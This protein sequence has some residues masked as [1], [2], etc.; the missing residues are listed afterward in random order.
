MSSPSSPTDRAALSAWPGGAAT[1]RV[2]VLGAGAIGGWM[3]GGFARA[4]WQVD[5][6]ARGATLAAL[7]RDGLTL[8][9]GDTT[10]RL[11]VQAVDDP[12]AIAGA[13]VLLLGLKGHDLPPALPS[14]RGLLGPATLVLSAQNG[15][16]WWF[17]RGFGGPAADRTLSG[18]DPGGQLAAALPAERVLAA[19]VHATSRVEAPGRIRLVGQDTVL[20]GDPTGMLAAPLAAVV[21]GLNAGG[22]TARATADI[23]GEIWLK[24]WGNATM[25]PLSALAGAD[26]AALLDDPGIAALVGA[27]MAEMAAIGDR[28]GLPI[29]QSAA[30]RIA[31]TRRL[32]AFRTSMLADREAGRAMER[33]PII[34]CLVELGAVL[35]VPVPNLAAVAGLLRLLE[36]SAG[37]RG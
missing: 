29:R 20:L 24:L 27:M 26:T 15:L 33:G 25:N 18:V 31:T 28:I 14:I 21:A 13:D 7:R 6:L 19:V 5:I 11:P 35:G 3:A 36:A 10:Q 2:A 9:E 37:P 34:G 8:L 12:A 23:R 4:G 17:L 30:T 22:I 32:G 1:P 16:P